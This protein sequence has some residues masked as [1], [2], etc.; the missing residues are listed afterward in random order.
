MSVEWEI[1]EKVSIAVDGMQLTIK[2]E[3]GELKK[4]LHSPLV[5]CELKGNTLLFS[6]K[7]ATKRENKILKTMRAHIKN[8][9]RGVTQ[10]YV[11][12]VKVCSGHFPM[13]V[14]FNN[15]KISIKNFLGEK[16]PRTLDIKEGAAV[17]VEGDIITITSID[18]ELAAQTAASIEN[19]TKRPGFD[20]RIFQDGC[21]IIEKDEKVIK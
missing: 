7:N 18:K 20:S 9:A 16:V 3:Q 12:K 21:Y 17:K 4:K 14:E 8:Y 1:P 2:G 15:N 6:V 19:L 10:A 5:K 11:Y 13:T